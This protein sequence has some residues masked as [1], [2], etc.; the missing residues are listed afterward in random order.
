M[1]KRSYFR[2]IPYIHSHK[3]FPVHISGYH[4]NVYRCKPYSNQKLGWTGDIVSPLALC[5]AQTSEVQCKLNKTFPFPTAYQVFQNYRYTV[6]YEKKKKIIIVTITLIVII[7]NNDNHNNDN[8]NNDYYY[9]NMRIFIKQ[10]RTLLCYLLSFKC[11][12]GC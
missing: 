5:L 10:K 8:N 1:V 2:V 6:R 3:G 9:K 7:N 11:K 4:N 12:R